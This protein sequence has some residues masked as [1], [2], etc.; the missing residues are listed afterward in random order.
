MSF[1]RTMQITA[2]ARYLRDV[3]RT[4]EVTVTRAHQ[5]SALV[6]FW[7]DAILPLLAAVRGADNIAI[8]IRTDPLIG[9]TL[10]MLRYLG[11]RTFTSDH[12]NAAGVKAARAWLSVPGRLLA[13][14]LDAGDPQVALPGVP[15]LARML[16][17][18]LCP[19]AVTAS[20]G[21][22]LPRWDRCVVPHLGGELTVRALEP[23][24]EPSL[25]ASVASLERALSAS[26]LVEPAARSLVPW[27]RALEFWPRWCLAPR[28]RG[29]LAVWP[30]MEPVEVSF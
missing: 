7:H 19:L 14:T 28:T 29:K 13:V 23:V 15:R 24:S 18:P 22:R 8:Y 1:V 25:E 27:R 10:D 5:G 21:F 12:R 6:T 3:Q 20:R 4:S 11:L 9:D 30:N 2:L 17:V 16:G 26:T